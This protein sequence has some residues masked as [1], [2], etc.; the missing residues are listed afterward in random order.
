MPLFVLQIAINKYAYRKVLT[1]FVRWSWFEWF[2]CTRKQKLTEWYIQTHS[3]WHY[4]IYDCV[5]MF[6]DHAPA[7]PWPLTFSSEEISKQSSQS[8]GYTEPYWSKY[9]PRC[10]QAMIPSWWRH[11]WSNWR[12]RHCI[13]DWWRRYFGHVTNFT[14]FSKNTISYLHASGKYVFSQNQTQ[15][16]VVECRCNKKLT[17]KIINSTTLWQI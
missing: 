6:N 12:W 7:Y 14:S 4:G 3:Q 17:G 1:R 11:W 2:I 8:Q 9:Q 15:P 13:L 16:R 5:I 10:R